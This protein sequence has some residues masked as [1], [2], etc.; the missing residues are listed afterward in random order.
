MWDGSDLDPVEGATNTM[1]GPPIRWVCLLSALM[2][3]IAG[4]QLQGQTIV[5]RL[6]DGESMQPIP[7]GFVQLL[8][9]D[10]IQAAATYGDDGGLFILDAP[11]PG[12]YLIQVEA[13]SYHSMQD[14]PVELG[15][16]DTVGVEFFV[17]PKPEELD[18]IVVE[19]Q[20]T[21]FRLRTSGFYRRQGRGTGQFITREDIDDIRPHDVSSLLV[22]GAPG[23]MLRP[24]RAG[25]MVAAFPAG[26]SSTSTLIGWCFPMYFLDGL[27][28]EVTD[29][30]IAFPIHPNDIAAV[31]VYSTRA[32]TPVQ[33]R[34]ARAR[35]G[36]VLIWSRW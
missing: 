14:G 21:E 25:A 29:N 6:L 28:L 33:Y 19:A 3:V 5:G 35:C 17:L 18:P 4:T 2:Q 22:W 8:D 32:D 13:F 30:D 26:R 7:R 20:R 15:P 23:I 1:R 16:A 11:R 27:P 12:M 34:D 9:S 24:N 31:E 10:S 36:T